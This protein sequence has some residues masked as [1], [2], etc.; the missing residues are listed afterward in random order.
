MG[1]ALL[2]PFQ[3]EGTNL[4][5]PGPGRLVEND[6]KAESRRNKSGTALTGRGGCI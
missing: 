2:A 4:G 3:L 6:L 5:S 1:K